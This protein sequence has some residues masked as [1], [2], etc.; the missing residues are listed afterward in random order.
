MSIGGTVMLLRMFDKYVLWL[1]L[2][3][4]DIMILPCKNA[5]VVDPRCVTYLYS[6]GKNLLW[7]DC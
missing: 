5:I 6:D 1:S 3:P 2:L 4:L 7:F